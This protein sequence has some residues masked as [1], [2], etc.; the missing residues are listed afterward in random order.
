MI[1]SEDGG[2]LDEVTK[3]NA[4][5][6]GKWL[7]GSLYEDSNDVLRLEF[8]EESEDEAGNVLLFLLSITGGL[9]VRQTLSASPVHLTYL[10]GVYT[11]CTIADQN[12][13][14]SGYQTYISRS[15]LQTA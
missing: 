13:R 10:T 8:P 4:L 7:S 12:T 5:R 15:M 3:G 14:S 6:E 11:V 9:Q 2:D 1:L